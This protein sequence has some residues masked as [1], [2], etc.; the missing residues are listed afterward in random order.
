MKIKIVFAVMAVFLLSTVGISSVV[1][2]DRISEKNDNPGD[3]EQILFL[4]KRALLAV[5][6][7]QADRAIKIIE[8][9]IELLNTKLKMLQ[10]EMIILHEKLVILYD[11]LTNCDPDDYEEIEDLQ[12]KIQ[13]IQMK[14]QDLQMEMNLVMMLI[15]EF[16]MAQEALFIPDF[17]VAEM[18]LKKAIE[19]CSTL[20]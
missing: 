19:I 10:E 16:E 8:G 5:K 6:N 20:I 3:Y 14:I 11:L 1:T 18:H 4:A 7:E 13:I 17:N 12:T 15:M 9:I 2:A